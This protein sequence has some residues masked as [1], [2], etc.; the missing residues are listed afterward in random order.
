MWH[1]IYSCK[2]FSCCLLRECFWISLLVSL[3][4]ALF[5]SLSG[6]GVIY[7]F[8]QKKFPNTAMRCAYTVPSHIFYFG[9]I[10]WKSLL[11]TWGWV[12]TSLNCL[13]QYF[14]FINFCDKLL[15]KRPWMA[16]KPTT[17]REFC[18][19]VRFEGLRYAVFKRPTYICQFKE[20][21]YYFL[22]EICK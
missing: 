8:L 9:F 21:K 2:T 11:A 20:K 6:L 4:P 22:N 13:F 12:E 5:G 7:F 1:Y 3:Y 14:K 18:L 19:E 15:H 16:I 17:W 10:W